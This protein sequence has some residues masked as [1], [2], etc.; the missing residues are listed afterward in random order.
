MANY[1]SAL[2]R[3]DRDGRTASDGGLAVLGSF[4]IFEIVFDLHSSCYF[5]RS[6]RIIL[7]RNPV[8]VGFVREWL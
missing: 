6:T 5:V 3:C 8:P 4:S 2:F 1:W 7:G